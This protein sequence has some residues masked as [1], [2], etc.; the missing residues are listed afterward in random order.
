MLSGGRTPPS[1][2][3]IDSPHEP[4]IRRKRELPGG[5]TAP[6]PACSTSPP[7][8]PLSMC[9]KPTVAECCTCFPV[10]HARQAAALRAGASAVASPIGTLPFT[11]ARASHHTQTQATSCTRFRAEARAS[12]RGPPCLG[13]LIISTAPV[14][15]RRVGQQTR[16]L[17]VHGLFVRRLREGRGPEAID[18]FGCSVN[19][20]LG[21]RSTDPHSTAV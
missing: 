4:C 14:S 16:P 11:S 21:S 2:M 5:C 20:P 3:P 1:V 18:S 10:C 15:L 7:V 8:S 19:L 6:W 17:V 12:P 13:H 9:S